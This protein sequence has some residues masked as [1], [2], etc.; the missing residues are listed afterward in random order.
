MATI[1]DLPIKRFQ[2]MSDEEL[3][4]AILASRSRR[5]TPPKEIKEAT[6]KKAIARKKQGKAAALKDPTSFLKGITP[7]DAQKLLAQLRSAK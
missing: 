1:E 5:R 2:E 7:E 4:D 3:L 6:I